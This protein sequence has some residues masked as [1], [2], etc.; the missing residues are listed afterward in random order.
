MWIIISVIAIIAFIAIYFYLVLPSLKKHPDAKLFKNL[1]VAHRGLHDIKSG[2]P[3]NS[4]ASY[5]KAVEYNFSIEID[6]RLTKDGQVVVFHDDNL[7]RI[8]GIESKIE[9][10]TLDEVKKLTLFD[11]KE[12]I[13]TL[14]EVLNV[15]DGKVVL[16]I[17][18]KCITN[19]KKLCVAANKV[20]KNYSGKYIVQSFNP[21]AMRWYKKKRRDILRGQLA[22]NFLK[23]PENNIIKTLVGWLLFNFLSRPH[24]ISYGI[25]YTN[26]FQ[27]RLCI[28]F[29]AIPVGW[30][31]KSNL[32]LEKYK[33][34]YNIY[35][36]EEF[37]PNT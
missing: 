35:I 4:I 18:F 2:I 13:P 34:K 27:R 25:E 12:K 8:C 21:F 1:Y 31:F 28:K 37:I 16:V 20:L 36:F 6:I 33:N 24:F 9:N 19:Y 7:R 10:M 14:N 5:K 26:S 3:E 15:I 17:E 23:E 11:T 29:G 22:T 30:T 32:D